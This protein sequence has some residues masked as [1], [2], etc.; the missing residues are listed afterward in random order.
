MMEESKLVVFFSVTGN[1]RRVA[2][3]ISRLTGAG[4][5]EIVPERTYSAE[6]LDYTNDLCRANREMAD[7]GCRPDIGGSLA[8]ADRA[9]EIWLGYPVWW[10]TA[11][12]IIDTFLDEH[13]LQG[14]TVH[15]FCTSGSSGIDQSAADLKAECP[16]VSFASG[17]R[18]AARFSES[19]VS[20]WLDSLN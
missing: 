2:E 16:G 5:L 6:D 9:D 10:G 8:A 1:T 7:S 14:R 19:Q 15:L 12:R 13:D 20:D 3:C 4:M 11:P 18:F 17:R